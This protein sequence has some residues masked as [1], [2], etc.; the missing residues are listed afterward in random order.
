MAYPYCTSSTSWTSSGERHPVKESDVRHSQHL[1]SR[2]DRTSTVDSWKHWSQEPKF[3]SRTPTA[4]YGIILG[5]WWRCKDPAYI[6][7][8]WTAM[9][10]CL[11][12]TEDTWGPPLFLLPQHPRPPQ[13]CH[14][15]R[16]AQRMRLPSRHAFSSEAQEFATPQQGC[17]LAK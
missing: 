16:H 6:W 4:R 10:V 12:E 7:S 3:T 9:D 11:Y 5:H 13:V 17:R 14:P 1:R 15:I 2:G 8:G